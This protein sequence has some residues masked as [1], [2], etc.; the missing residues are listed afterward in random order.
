MQLVWVPGQGMRLAMNLEGRKYPTPAQVMRKGVA[1]KNERIGGY[2]VPKLTSGAVAHAVGAQP[3]FIVAEVSTG[4]MP[5][6]VELGRLKE[7]RAALGPGGTLI[8]RVR[9]DEKSVESSLKS[10]P[11]NMAHRLADACR[12]VE[13]QLGQKDVVDMW[14][15]VRGVPPNLRDEYAAMEKEWVHVMQPLPVVAYCFKSGLVP[16]EP[17]EW[18]VFREALQYDNVKGIGAE[19]YWWGGQLKDTRWDGV[20]QFRVIKAAESLRTARGREAVLPWYVMG[21]GFSEYGDPARGW[22]TL[23]IPEVIYAEHLNYYLGRYKDYGR[24]FGVA[25]DAMA[26]PGSWRDRQLGVGGTGLLTKTVRSF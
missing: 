1:R 2:L 15:S 18:D 14:A 9:E 26:D 20:R 23:G 22:R 19:E 21:A 25:I 11:V 17:L 24:V 16:T 6:P 8:V 13:M 3:S 5:G 4:R 10:S 7:L 12:M